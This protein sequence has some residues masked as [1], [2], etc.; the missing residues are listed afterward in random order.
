MLESDTDDTVEEV[1]MDHILECEQCRSV[2]DAM[3]QNEA[4]LFRLL[5]TSSREK[6]RNRWMEGTECPS[7]ENLLR[8]VT[9]Q[10]TADEGVKVEAH[11]QQ[12]DFCLHE[13]LN[14]QEQ[15]A[16]QHD[17]RTDLDDYFE[18]P[19]SAGEGIKELLRVVMRVG[20]DTMEMIQQSGQLIA[21]R[22][23]IARKGDVG[24]PSQGVE[25]FRVRKDDVEADFSVQVNIV[26][27]SLY[28]LF[29][30]RLSL[31]S[32]SDE[33]PLSG[34]DVQLEKESS[35]AIQAKTDPEGLLAFT[36]LEPATYV[37]VVRR[38]RFTRS[39][40]IEVGK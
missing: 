11:L 19:Q 40:I 38:G 34:I 6:S 31:M 10:L 37:A 29:D 23:I 7:L 35:I 18:E 13:V 27:A 33:I 15:R 1:R 5:P 17:V 32:L 14:L 8:F 21:H 12:C 3:I 2:Y 25:T 22:P 20:Q 36:E 9:D 30:I 16:M 4:V 28:P 24:K 39:I 26:K